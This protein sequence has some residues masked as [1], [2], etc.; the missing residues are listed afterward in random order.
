MKKFNLKSNINLSFKDSFKN[1]K[2]SFKNKK[3]KH[4]SYM[5]IS[6]IMVLCIVIIL[7]LFIGKLNIKFDLTKNKLY[8]LSDQSKKILKS[9]NKDVTIIGLYEAGKEDTSVKE[10]LNQYEKASDKIK[11]QYK[12]PELYPEFVKKYSKNDSNVGKGDLIVECGNK[13]KV[14]SSYDLVSYNGYNASLTAEQN[15]TGAINYVTSD[16]VT[17]IYF[18]QGHNEDR[19]PYDIINS[20]ENQNYEIK[21]IN[22]LTDE[23][24]P[25]DG[26]LM[27]MGPKVDLT[28]SE[29][30]KVEDFM[31][32]GG[33]ALIT[34]PL[35]KSE[36]TNLNKF[37]SN[38]G[39]K[40]ENALIIEANNSNKLQNPLYIIPNAQSQ[41]IVSPIS[42]LKYPI[43]LQASHP[44]TKIDLVKHTIKIEPLLKTS[45]KSYA[46]TNLES[47]TINKESDDLEGPFTVASAITDDLGLGD[48]NTKLVVISSS[49][50]L[51]TSLTVNG[52]GNTDLFL[53]SVNWLE[54]KT[55]N[56][57][58]SPKDLS[59]SYLYIDSSK[60][61][62]FSGISVILIP[63]IVVITGVSVCLRRKKL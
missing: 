63:L 42:S 35:M 16:E 19:L 57:S 34:V 1:F 38:Y 24:N 32:D 31:K 2:S 20:L 14:L 17:T 4:G 52:L 12:D 33:H 18:T 8:T 13:F 56:I 28:P 45:D 3:F 60:Q 5:T 29:I 30:S 40:L 59:S 58:V 41:E 21:N 44:I 61:L 46:K 54:N 26:I 37:L 39:V 48:K 55:Q 62:L 6:T 7:N 49:N 27:I 51:D 11:V 43:V 36:P 53:N 15:I 22:L 50:F 9:L 47:N 23:I 25:N 10:I